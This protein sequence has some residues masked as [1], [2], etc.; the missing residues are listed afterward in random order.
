MSLA[1]MPRRRRPVPLPA[2]VAPAR[3][4]PQTTGDLSALAALVNAAPLNHWIDTNI[5]PGNHWAVRSMIPGAKDAIQ[6]QLTTGIP[7]EAQANYTVGAEDTLLNSNGVAYFP[8]KKQIFFSGGGHGGWPGNEVYGVDL[9]S[10]SWWRQT[11][12]SPMARNAN[13]TWRNL[14]NTPI[15]TH[16][17]NGI[18]AVESLNCFFVL[19]GSPWPLGNWF[20]Q[21]WRFDIDTSVWTYLL[22]DPLNRT[23]L[24]HAIWVES[25]QKIALGHPQWWRWYDP[26]TGALG[27]VQNSFQAG[28][29]FANGMAVVAGGQLY[30][31]HNTAVDRVALADLGTV[32]PTDLV[33]T[34]AYPQFTAYE[35]WDRV[36]SGWNSYLWD[37][38]RA[39]VIAWTGSYTGPDPGR[40]MWA[41]DFA[42]GKL[43]EFP[44]TGAW[45]D[46]GAGL[47][48][49]SKFIYISELDCYLMLNNAAVNNGWMVVRPGPMNL[50]AE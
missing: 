22:T 13:G 6:S 41:I 39:M 40:R 46:G 30:S 50:V 43:Y 25:E 15:S 18:C 42:L 26:F 8:L 27:P 21:L 37:P 38:L 36:M 16:T 2:G 19:T 34:N 28:D 4:R 5:K 49:F 17:Y 31:F 35:D 33:A 45:P 14:D 12:P 1:L 48:A 7:G 9:E 11:D 20:N 24:P 44:L 32:R 23:G 10:M 47:G 29:R 3:A